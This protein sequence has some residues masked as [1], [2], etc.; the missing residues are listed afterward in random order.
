MGVI[1]EI[2]SG[3]T[4][5]AQRTAAN[6]DATV[7][8]LMLLIH[9][10]PGGLHGVLQRLSERGLAPQ[11]QTWIADGPNTPVFADQMMRAVGSR[12]L[13][14]VA[15][16]FG[17]D[18]EIVASSVADLLPDLVDRLTP[19]GHADERT[20]ESGVASFKGMIRGL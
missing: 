16:Q 11:V 14:R 12:Q 4:G 13:Q 9:G 15:Q 18:Q 10:F 8:M 19:R 7:Q 17:V 5:E 2:I 3:A 6:A 20:L 1:D